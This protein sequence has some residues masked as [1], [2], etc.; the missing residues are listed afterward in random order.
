[1]IAGIVTDLTDWLD[2]VSS[3]WWFLL[4]ILVIAYLDSVIPIVPS[5]TCVIIGGVAASL[6]N[7]NI[8][9]VIGFAAVG[10]FLGDNTA[11]QIG[12]RASS[13]FQR[14]ANRKP[15]FAK[16][17]RWAEDQIAERGGL[18][19]ITARFIPGGRTALTLSCGITRQRRSWFIRWVAVA[20]VIWA[21]YAALLGRIGG[22]AFENDHTKAFL[23]AFGLAIATN[24]LIEIVR[25]TR[26]RR[27]ASAAPVAPTP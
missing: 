20:A 15:A 8:Y 10:A 16:K 11:Y 22:E 2:R 17:M 24:V 5:E 4:I 1:M 21:T 26:K 3:H 6:G 25:H 23:L 13:R 12:L 9:A 19:L 7:Q 27:R 18:L 14:R